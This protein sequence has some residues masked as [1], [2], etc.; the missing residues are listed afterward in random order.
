[1]PRGR[2]YLAFNARTGNGLTIARKYR[3]TNFL[4]NVSSRRS[5][6]QM[7]EETIGEICTSLLDA[8]CRSVPELSY[9]YT[10]TLW[11]ATQTTI[12]MYL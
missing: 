7:Q 11:S 3:L 12:Y 4:V 1:M 9:R 5:I 8:R 6:M 2:S 10:Y